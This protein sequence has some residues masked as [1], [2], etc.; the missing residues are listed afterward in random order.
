MYM[1]LYKFVDMNENIKKILVWLG[2]SILMMITW[3]SGIFI[4]NMIFP[5]SLMEMSADSSVNTELM[6][7]IICGLNT[8]VILYLIYNSKYT[9]WKLVGATFLVTFGIQYFMTQIETL[10]FNDS[11]SMPIN[12]IYA[13]V[14]G[15]AISIIIFSIAATWITG[16]FKRSEKAEAQSVKGELKPLLIRI[17][18][19]SV[20]IWPIVYFMAG[21]LIAWQFAELRLFYSGTTEM[22]SFLSIMEENIASG[23]YYFQFF[24]GF[25]WV[26]IG[27]LVLKMTNRPILQ[28]GVILGLLLSILGSSQLLLPNPFMSDMVRMGHLLETGSSNFIW[29]FIIAISLGSVMEKKLI[30]PGTPVLNTN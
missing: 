10:W 5:S 6:L 26:L 12:G 15:G 8:W 2:L 18:L 21:Y 13:I 1:H 14:S 16:N 20:V 30:D 4:G 9:G 22:A 7:F 17:L 29:G 24:R 25:L 3:I 23:L 28:K 19:L 27:L 11:L